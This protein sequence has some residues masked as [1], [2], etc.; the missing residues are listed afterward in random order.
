MKI[1]DL[2]Q[3]MRAL[4]TDTFHRIPPSQQQRAEI[5]AKELAQRANEEGVAVV[6][7]TLLASADMI[8]RISRAMGGA[9]TPAS[10]G[11]ESR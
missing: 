5:V 10:D 8:E 7:G 1:E 9:P 11:K 3:S 4:A 2:L 6:I